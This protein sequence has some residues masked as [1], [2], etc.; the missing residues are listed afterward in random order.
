MGAHRNNNGNMAVY[1]TI[2]SPFQD[3]SRGYRVSFDGEKAATKGL[4]MGSE[5]E[6]A[7]PTS[8]EWHMVDRLRELRKVSGAAK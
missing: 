1:T 3:L 7:A 6:A 2:L 5:K 8:T 4:F